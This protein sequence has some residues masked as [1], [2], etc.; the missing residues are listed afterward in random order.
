M[1]VAAQ[2][3]GPEARPAAAGSFGDVIGAPGNCSRTSTS[4]PNPKT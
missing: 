2:V 3:I 4:S 1:S